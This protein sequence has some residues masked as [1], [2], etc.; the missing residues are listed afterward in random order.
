M[1]LD[2]AHKVDALPE[3]VMREE[4]GKVLE[5]TIENTAAADVSKI[6]QHSENARFTLMPATLYTP[7]GRRPRKL[8]GGKVL[9]D[10]TR[11]YPPQLWAAIQKVRAV[12][13]ANRIAARGLA[14]QSWLRIAEKWGINVTVPGYVRKAVPTS[15]KQYDDESARVTRMPNELTY[16]LENSQPTVNAIGGAKALQSAVDGRTEFFHVN[17]AHGVFDDMAN[18]AKKYPG[19]KIT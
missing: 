5:K 14:K 11:R 13:L 9:Y 2:L 17:M 7:R 8:I 15:K 12:D 3:D 18:I 19:I 4:I 10:L 1:C 6:R 16:E